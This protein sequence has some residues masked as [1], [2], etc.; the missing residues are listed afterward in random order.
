VLKDFTKF[1]DLRY[2]LL[3]GGH[4]YEGQFE[5]LA[6]NPDIIV[7]TP[8]RLMQLLVETE[9]K[10]S[11]VEMLIFDEADS[12]FEKGFEMQM[13][14]I[15]KRCP[16]SQKLMFSATIPDQL[17]TFANSGLRDYVYVKHDVSLPEKMSLDFY[18]LRN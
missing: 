12:L 3:L 7:A 2:A 10:L 16:V 6:S 18:V 17:N 11:R 9:L 4:S 5:C 13:T 14:E 1:T 8:G 15:L